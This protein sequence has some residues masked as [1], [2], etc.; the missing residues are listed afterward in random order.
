MADNAQ[1][2]PF[3]RS[4]NLFAQRR[5]LDAIQLLGKALP[6]S[7][8]AVNGSIVTVKFEVQSLFTLPKVTIPAL[9]WQYVRI[10]IQVGD[11]GMVMPADADL[12]GVDGLGHGTAD[13]TTPANLS[14]LVF[15][16]VASKNWSASEDPNAVVIYGPD[17]VVL[18]DAGKKTTLTLTPTGI[19][20][21]L[22]A[23]DQVAITGDLAVTGNLLLGGTIQAHPGG[24]YTGAIQ[25]SGNVIAGFGTGD[26]VGLQ[27]HTHKQG[28]DSRGDTEQDVLAPTAGT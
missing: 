6:A 13:L 15:V 23:G 9:V 26:Q 2:V 19:V 18:R 5:A 17:G 21:T 20:I 24:T 8:T 4:M 22:P 12:G 16:P 10:P 14:A 27:T 25:T 11:T 7:V 1:K 28:V 3:V